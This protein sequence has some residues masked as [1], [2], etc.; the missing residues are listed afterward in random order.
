MVFINHKAKNQI[1]K[2]TEEQRRNKGTWAQKDILMGQKT[3]EYNQN[4]YQ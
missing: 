1:N 3:G 2:G 4:L